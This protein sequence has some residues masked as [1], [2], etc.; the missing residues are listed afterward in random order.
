[1]CRDLERCVDHNGEEALLQGIWRKALDVARDVA[2][3]V[4]YEVLFAV[5]SHIKSF[6]RRKVPHESVT[7]FFI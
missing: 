3:H 2:R 5:L 1:M 4:G 7:L 6:C